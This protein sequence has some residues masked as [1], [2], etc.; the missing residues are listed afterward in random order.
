MMG[1]TN[2]FLSLWL[3]FDASCRE[4]KT[5]GSFQNAA[6]LG[7]LLS[8]LR[9]FWEEEM[10]SLGNADRES[11]LLR[12]TSLVDGE[13]MPCEIR[14]SK[15]E[16]NNPGYS[17]RKFITDEQGE[18]EIK[19][20]AGMWKAETGHGLT[21]ESA[22]EDIEIKPGKTVDR[23]VEL[24][25]FVDLK[26]M[27]WYNGELHHH[28][29]YSSPVY[30]G[31]DDVVDTPAQVRLSMEAAGCDFGALSDHHNILNHEEWKREEKHS[32]VHFIPVI[33]KEIS[34]SNG[35]VMAMGAKK[36]I[37]YDIPDKTNRTEERLRREF[38]KV[39][40]EIK[41]AG[42]ITQV[43]HPFSDSF[44]TSWQPGFTDLLSQFTSLEI[45]NGANPMLD[46]NGNGKAFR[47]WLD[48]LNKGYRITATAGSDTHCI[49]TNQY[50]EIKE[51]L[52][53]IMRILP[54]KRKEIPDNLQDKIR[55]LEEMWDKS[56]AWLNHWIQISL[57]T[58]GVRNY[59]YSEEPI[60]REK[61]LEG[62]QS[63]R[64]FITNGPLLFPSIN[65]AGPGETQ[66]LESSAADVEVKL[67]SRKMPKEI[68]LYLSN[69][70]ILKKQIPPEN[71]QGFFYHDT[72]QSVNMK[73]SEWVVCAA[74]DDCTNLAVANPIRLA[75]P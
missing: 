3:E 72:F 54:G 4:D 22:R 2:K 25:R 56:Y 68:R 6:E 41:K 10:T 52:Q 34:T 28:S 35:H 73:D 9:R 12:V 59:I 47:L 49:K 1:I 8:W 60:G 53:L 43:N 69:G 14:L 63:G 16:E 50:E 7:E 11:G 58:A 13:L 27:G 75:L 37:V 38:L 48:L 17:F 36:D 33:S 57:G 39:V 30:G 24:H 62:I 31:T 15:T 29:I 18:I 55:I 71:V 67:W 5:S 61:V 70:K 42:G 46:D 51:E 26:K 65:G 20:P 44:S 74:G 64:V 32:K 45:W 21:V 66:V 40:R 19:L 23:R